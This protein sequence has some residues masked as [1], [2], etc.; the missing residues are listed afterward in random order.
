[1]T[2]TPY[3]P[4]MTDEHYQL[5]RKIY[6]LKQEVEELKK[7]L[8]EKDLLLDRYIGAIGQIRALMEKV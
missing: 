2:N 3:E 8:T 6:E 5:R 4:Q 1:M 7:Q